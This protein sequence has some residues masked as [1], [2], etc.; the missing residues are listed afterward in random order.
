MKIHFHPADGPRVEATLPHH[1]ADH[2]I[3]PGACPACKASPFAVAGVAGS[4]VEGHD[5]MTSSAGCTSC[6]A[7]LGQLVV[8]VATLFGIHEDRAVLQ[9]RCR[10]Y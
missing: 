10:V 6:K 3:V 4:M 5:T 9:G 1:D 7:V 8:T 2:V